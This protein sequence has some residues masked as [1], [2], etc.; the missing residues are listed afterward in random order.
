M[1]IIGG[2]IVYIVVIAFSPILFSWACVVKYLE[3]SRD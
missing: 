2:I 3:H 1:Y